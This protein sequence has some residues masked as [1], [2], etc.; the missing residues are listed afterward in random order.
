MGWGSDTRPKDVRAEPRNKPFPEEL[1]LD[2]SGKTLMTAVEYLLSRPQYEQDFDDDYSGDDINVKRA[3]AAT[4]SLLKSKDY[5]QATVEKVIDDN[6]L[7]ALVQNLLI[8]G[9]HDS[10]NSGDHNA[11]VDMM[12]AYL[13]ISLDFHHMNF[14]E[15]ITLG[16][17]LFEPYKATAEQQQKIIKAIAESRKIDPEFEEDIEE[18]QT[19]GY[20]TAR[21]FRKDFVKAMWGVLNYTKDKKYLETKIVILGGGPA[22]ILTARTLTEIG[23]SNIQIL[24]DSGK[25]NGIW[26]MNSVSKG[27][28]NNPFNI[29]FLGIYLPASTGQQGSGAK[30]L[31]FLDQV[32]WGRMDHKGRREKD[33]FIAPMPELIKTKVVGVKAGNLMHEIQCLSTKGEI[34]IIK[35]P[36][37]INA[38]GL[39][40]PTDLNDEASPMKTTTPKL[41]GSRWQVQITSELAKKMSG[42]NLTIIG[43]GNSSIEMLMQ[44]HEWNHKGYD[45]KY[46]VLTHYPKESIENPDSYVELDGR[47]YRVFRDLTKSNLVDLEGDIPAAREAYMK[48]VKDGNVISDVIE[49]NRC[50]ETKTVTVK[51]RTGEQLEIPTDQQLTLTGYKPSLDIYQHMNINLD[52][53]DCPMYDYDGEIHRTPNLREDLGRTYKGYSVIGAIRANDKEPN[54]LVI[55]GIMDSLP[56]LVFNTI[57]RA[58]D[59]SNST[60]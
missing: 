19:A 36:I 46:K 18:R 10:I 43:V 52:S 15:F 12:K 58:I 6:S 28:I 4:A 39:G 16:D 54:A 37:V 40:K 55:P 32:I 49:W 2:K 17:K 38:L 3:L 29:N 44:I 47:Q 48:A 60:N 21:V 24:D 35:A 51:L 57:F 20:G 14:E 59:F 11:S 45:I 23:F 34:E 42:K 26:R 25:F 1:L 22:G 9:V 31:R 30:L 53:D 8:K 33:Y 13:K 56:K 27:T 7:N 41:C 50:V 5:S